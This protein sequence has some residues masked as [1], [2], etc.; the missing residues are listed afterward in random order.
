MADAAISALAKNLVRKLMVLTPNV[1]KC[2]KIKKLDDYLV[3]HC[4]LFPSRFEV[5]L[6]PVAPT[7]TSKNLVRVSLKNCARLSFAPNPLRLS[8]PDSWE[9]IAA[10]NTS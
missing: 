8:L 6:E 1:V 9:G 5:I 4:Q 10:R 2:S 3:G 7:A